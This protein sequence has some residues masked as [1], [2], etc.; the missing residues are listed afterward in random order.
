VTGDTAVQ[1]GTYSVTPKAGGNAMNYKYTATFVR[2]GG[3]WMPIAFNTR[4][5]PQK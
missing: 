1:S 5:M 3:R 2:R 4:A